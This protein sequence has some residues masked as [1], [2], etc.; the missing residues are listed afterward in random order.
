MVTFVK[1]REFAS[2]L[3]DGH[4]GNALQVGREF[5]VARIRRRTSR[6]CDRRLLAVADFERDESAGGEGGEGCGMSRR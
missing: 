3:R 4:A 6:V 5:N 1:S 2:S